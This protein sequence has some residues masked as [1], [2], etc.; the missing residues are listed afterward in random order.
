MSFTSLLNEVREILEQELSRLDVMMDRYAKPKKKM[1]GGGKVHK[2]MYAKGG[3][4]RKAK[5]YG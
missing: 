3:G 1:M 5:T 4:I 2:K